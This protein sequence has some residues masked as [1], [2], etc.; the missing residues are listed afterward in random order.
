MRVPCSNSRRRF[1]RYLCHSKS[2]A[3]AVLLSV[4]EVRRLLPVVTFTA[5]RV[6][7]CERAFPLD[8][9][10]CILAFRLSCS[11]KFVFCP[12]VPFPVDDVRAAE[13]RFGDPP[14]QRRRRSPGRSS[15]RSSPDR[16]CARRPLLGGKVNLRHN[17]LRLQRTATSPL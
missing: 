6:R 7:T 2:T 11:H 13:E 14:P 17:Q 3:R 8:F 5:A 1:S 12:L 16:R 10:A 15:G 4:L 9:L